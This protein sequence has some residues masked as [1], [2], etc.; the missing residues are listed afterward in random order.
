MSSSLALRVRKLLAR[1]GSLRLRLTLAVA[2]LGLLALSS[3]AILL[4]WTV[5]ATVLS[6]IHRSNA[7]E[8]D[9]VRAQ[10]EQGV[11]PQAL[12]P[13]RGFLRIAPPP[14]NSACAPGVP[15]P[16]LLQPPGSGWP[17]PP[18]APGR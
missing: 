12:D 10:L 6:G 2:I 13:P 4:V 18:P 3:G 17:A 8:L 14:G 1:V 5:Q 11:P 9:T 15:A 7:E 16:A